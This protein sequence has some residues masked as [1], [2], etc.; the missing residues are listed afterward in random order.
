MSQKV[1]SSIVIKNE[2][3][4]IAEIFATYDPASRGG[5]PADRKQHKQRTGADRCKR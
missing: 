5:D 3:G 1:D 2:D 4:S